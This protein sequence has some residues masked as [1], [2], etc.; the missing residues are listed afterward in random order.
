[1]IL[2]FKTFNDLG[3]Q[4]FSVMIEFILFVYFLKL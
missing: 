4:F 2:S 1:M 3:S